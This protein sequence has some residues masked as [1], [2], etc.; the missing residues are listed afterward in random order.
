MF[1]GVCCVTFVCI[2]LFMFDSFNWNPHGLVGCAVVTTSI[3]VPRC[4]DDIQTLG[5]LSS[6]V[7]SRLILLSYCL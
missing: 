2:C 4:H 7:Y 5:R 1:G 3:A 6:L